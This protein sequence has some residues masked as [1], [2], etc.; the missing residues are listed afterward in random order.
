[1]PTE[2]D[3]SGAT[4]IPTPQRPVYRVTPFEAHM[5]WNTRFILKRRDIFGHDL[6]EEPPQNLQSCPGPLP[7]GLTPNAYMVLKDTLAQG[8]ILTLNRFGG[9]MKES[10]LRDGQP[11]TG[12]VWDRH[13]PEETRLGFSRA[14]VEFL[15]ALTADDFIEPHHYLV[16]WDCEERRLTPAD[17]FFFWRTLD[18]ARQVSRNLFFCLVRKQ[19]FR[20]NVWGW[21]SFPAEMIPGQSYEVTPE[22][23]PDF[24]ECTRGVRGM[25]LECLQLALSWRWQRWI[26]DQR[27][28]SLPAA[29]RQGQHRLVHKVLQVFLEAMASARRPDLARFLLHTLSR[30]LN[31]SDM[32]LSEWLGKAIHHSYH[33]LADIRQYYSDMLLFPCGLMTTLLKW[34]NRYRLTG[35]LDEDYRV[36]Q[37]WLGEWERWNGNVAAAV[38]DRLDEQSYNL[39]YLKTP[40]TTTPPQAVQW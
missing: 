9:W 22:N 39:D 35:Y 21:L 10:F 7:D 5:L 32:T 26:E 11:Q 40:E 16:D 13:P 8:T 1:M 29:V 25:I 23:L 12:S 15:M 34:R 37:W 27:I 17:E 6:G 31:R 2:S 20:R 38:A 19:A 28:R 33:R 3:N 30:S 14:V 4:K 36:A 24:S 18:V